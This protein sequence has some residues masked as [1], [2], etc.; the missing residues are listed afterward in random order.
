MLTACKVTGA[1]SLRLSPMAGLSDLVYCDISFLSVVGDQVT[2]QS[3][4]ESKFDFQQG[5][6]SLSLFI[7]IYIYIKWSL[8]DPR[9]L[10]T[11]TG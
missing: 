4:E 5:K 2:S 8:W 6:V 10:I 11:I 1:T 3:A 7:Y 9:F